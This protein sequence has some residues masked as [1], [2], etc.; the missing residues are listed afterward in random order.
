MLARLTTRLAVAL[1]LALVG[2]GASGQELP[3][4]PLPKMVDKSPDTTTERVREIPLPVVPEMPQPVVAPPPAPKPPAEPPVVPTGPPHD[5][6]FSAQ[7]IGYSFRPAPLAEPLLTTSDADGTRTLIGASEAKFG[8]SNALGLTGGLWLDDKHEYGLEVGGFVTRRRV[9]VSEVTAA[10]DQTVTRPFVD[11]LTGAPARFFVSAPGFL[12]GSFRAE[13]A[14][15]LGG[16]T[17]RILSNR[18]HMCELTIDL[19][20]G[21]ICRSP[22]RNRWRDLTPLASRPDRRT[23]WKGLLPQS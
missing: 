11:T 20:A 3:P 19:F 9:A 12:S 17:A 4:R 14:A 7:Y 5:V 6:W 23:V 21:R 2:G 18:V 22:L 15:R 8:W 16:A 10:P 1:G 13:S